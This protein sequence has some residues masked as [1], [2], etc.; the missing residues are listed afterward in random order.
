MKADSE[1][2]NLF[3][4]KRFLQPTRISFTGIIK[5]P[6]P[7]FFWTK[8]PNV[9]DSERQEEISMLLYN[10]VPYSASA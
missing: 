9:W 7:K 4:I 6:S 2:L 8:P 10:E 3:L 5:I 1:D